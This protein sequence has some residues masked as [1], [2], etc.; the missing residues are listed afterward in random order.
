[1][2]TQRE[3]WAG[4]EFELLMHHELAKALDEL[5]WFKPRC[6][7]TDRLQPAAPGAMMRR[8]G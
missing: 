4:D 3:Y 1:M 2:P 8:R 5:R 6:C 7:L